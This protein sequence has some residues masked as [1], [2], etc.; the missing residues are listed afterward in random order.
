M[1]RFALP[2]VILAA[3]TPGCSSSGAVGMGPVTNLVAPPK[4]V[5]NSVVRIDPKTLKPVQ[6]VPVGDDPDLVVDAGG[7]I[8]VTNHMLSDRNGPA[9][10][11][12]G[13]RTLTRVDPSTGTARQV[14]GGLSPCGLSPGPPG[15]VLV[16]NCFPRN[17]GQTPN[18]VRVDARTFDLKSWPVPGGYGFFRGVG[19]GGGWVWTDGVDNHGSS[20]I[21]INPRTGVKQ[22][23]HVSFPS[24]G[25]SPGQQR[26]A[27]FGSTT[28][29]AAAI[30]PAASPDCTRGTEPPH[31]STSQPTPCSRP[32]PATRCGLETGSSSGRAPRH[33]GIATPRIIGLPVHNLSA[34]V[35]NVAA[36][37]GYI[38]ATTPRDGTLWRIN[39]HTDHVTRIPMPYLPT[40]VTANA[41][42][43]WVTVRGE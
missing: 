34:G 39:P 41:T 15:T 12:N 32:W 8:W 13:D 37:A 3:L 26:T 24:R 38:W 2:I 35:W 30:T 22:S 43:V 33:L 21:R 1:R 25:R 10:I 42:G 7:Y 18:I 4:V 11:Y 31:S 36:G 17:S 27:T 29:A 14:G 6:V 16:A 9:D 20:V 23:I 28:P 19:Y 5:P 40:M